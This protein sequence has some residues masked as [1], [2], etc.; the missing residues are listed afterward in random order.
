MDIS[1][2]VRI[3]QLMISSLAELAGFTGMLYAPNI[4]YKPNGP[5]SGKVNEEYTYTTFTYDPQGD[6]VLYLFD[7]DDGTDSGWIG[8]YASGETAEASHI[9]TNKNTYNIKVKAKDINGYESD[10]SDPLEIS[11]PRNKAMTNTLF[12]RFLERFP[13]AFPLIRHILGL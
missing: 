4:P 2:A 7:W 12:L 13:N 1:Y 6:Q 8:P 10:W 11:M 5:P 3:S 9:W